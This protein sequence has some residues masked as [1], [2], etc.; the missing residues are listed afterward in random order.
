[1]TMAKRVTFSAEEDETYFIPKLSRKESKD[2]FYQSEDIAQFRHQAVLEMAGLVCLEVSLEKVEVA[3]SSVKQLEPD[4]HNLD[5]CRTMARV[6]T[7]RTAQNN[8]PA[9][10]SPVG[11]AETSISASFLLTKDSTH[12]STPPRPSRGEREPSTRTRQTTQRTTQRPSR[13]NPLEVPQEKSKFTNSPN[14][15]PAGNS[16]GDRQP[17]RRTKRGEGTTTPPRREKSIYM[18][19]ALHEVPPLSQ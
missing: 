8:R 19:S 6:R 9:R 18:I 17:S 13:S 5:L 7:R 11:R 2:L 15:S 14:S 10:L 12:D 4:S 3:T 1:M 16:I